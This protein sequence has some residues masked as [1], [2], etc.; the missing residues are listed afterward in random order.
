MKTFCIS[1]TL[2]M[3]VVM[4]GSAATSHSS[5]PVRPLTVTA[6]AS[7]LFAPLTQDLGPLIDLLN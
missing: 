7:A 2:L 3:S 4:L 1:L 5:A 6:D